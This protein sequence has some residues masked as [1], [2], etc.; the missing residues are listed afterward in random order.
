M[1]KPLHVLIACRGFDVMVCKG[2]ADAGVSDD[3]PWPDD[4]IRSSTVCSGYL[5][6]VVPGAR[7][8]SV[9]FAALWRS[10]VYTFLPSPNSS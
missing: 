6:C 8:G 1:Q 9:S 2:G 3:P 4:L 7:F 5:I 10:F